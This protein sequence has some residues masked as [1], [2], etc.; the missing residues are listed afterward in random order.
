VGQESGRSATT[1][2]AIDG[3]RMV[4][5]GLKENSGDPDIFPH[6]AA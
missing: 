5:R 3:F 6:R 2:R 1:V 4:D